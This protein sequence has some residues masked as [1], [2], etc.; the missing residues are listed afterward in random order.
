MLPG[1]GE[2]ALGSRAHLV[3]RSHYCA[4]DDENFSSLCVGDLGSGF[5]LSIDGKYSIVGVAS[6]ITNMCNNKF[7]AIYTY[8][9]PYIDWINGIIKEIHDPIYEC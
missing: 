7:P 5:V 8:V 6:V 2:L 3:T 9:A 4:I 1:L